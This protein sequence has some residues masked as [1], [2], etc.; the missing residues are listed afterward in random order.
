[1]CV[2]QSVAVCCSVSK[3]VAV[4]VAGTRTF[5]TSNCLCCRCMTFKCVTKCMSSERDM[6]V[7][8]CCSV[9]QCVVVSFS[10]L[11]CVAGTEWDLSVAGM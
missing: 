6:L 8:V 3:C 4:C 5:T 10:V 11:Q 2:L 9:L 1:M 7:A